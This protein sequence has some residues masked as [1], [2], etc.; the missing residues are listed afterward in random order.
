MPIGF[1]EAFSR[2][3]VYTGLSEQGLFAGILTKAG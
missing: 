1:A 3:P 2:C